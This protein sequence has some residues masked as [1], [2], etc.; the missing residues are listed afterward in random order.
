MENNNDNNNNIGNNLRLPLLLEPQL[1]PPQPQAIQDYFQPAAN[2]NYSKIVHQPIYMNNFKLKL[3]LI[4][5]VHH[6]SFG[7]GATED[8]NKYL[9]M[10]LE[11]YDTIKLNRVSKDTI[12]LLFFPFSLRDKSRSWLQTL[13]SGSITTQD[14]TSQKF[15]AK[16]F[17]LSK[18][19]HLKSEIAQFKHQDFEALYEAWDTPVWLD[20]WQQV[21][22]FYNG[23]NGQT[24][25]II[26]AAIG[27]TLIAKTANDAYA[28]LGEMTT[29]YYQWPSER[30]SVK[31]VARVLKLDPFNTLSVQMS[32]IQNQ[33]AN[34]TKSVPQIVH[35]NTKQS[36]PTNFLEA[37]VKDVNFVND[38]NFYFKGNQVPNQYHPELQNHKKISYANNRNVL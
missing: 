10:L 9:A 13:A 1:T 7:R 16:F 26:D 15:L 12:H 21:Q 30:S 27:G 19:L 29:N 31:K 3:V 22:Y 20:I 38:S 18:T 2:Q 35:V 37:T 14:D 6:N 33:L 11:V 28:L 25:T 36:I 24:R 4:G 32:A 34:L 8:L 17:P 23:L 5:M